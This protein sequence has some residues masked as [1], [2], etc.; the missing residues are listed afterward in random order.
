MEK[1]KFNIDGVEF[2]LVLKYFGNN[3]LCIELERITNI[4]VKVNLIKVFKEMTSIIVNHIDNN[5][6]IQIIGSIFSPNME[7]SL[8]SWM[9]ICEYYF[10]KH[11]SKIGNW[12][13]TRNS[14]SIVI[15]RI[16]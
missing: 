11:K 12:K 5:K 14:N 10:N 9:N 6:N 13:T 3:R 4:N 2:Y 1:T 7:I 8:K 15:E 16:N